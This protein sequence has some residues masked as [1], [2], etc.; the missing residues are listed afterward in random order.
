MLWNIMKTGRDLDDET[1]FKLTM[2]KLDS[3]ECSENGYILDDFPTYS[4][5]EHTILNQLDSLM[6]LANRAN[7]F[8]HI[9]VIMI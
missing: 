5:K 8:I 1:V 4:Q 6:L 7:C 2:D 9:K 3:P